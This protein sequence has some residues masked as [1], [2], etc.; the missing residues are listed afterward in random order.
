MSKASRSNSG[1]GAGALDLSQAVNYISQVAGALAYAHD[2]GVIHRDIKPANI[3]ITPYGLVKLMD[4]GIASASRDSR[5]TKTGTAVGSLFYMSPEQITGLTPDARSDLYSLGVTFYEMVTGRRPIEGANDYTI[6][7]GHMNQVPTAPMLV[8]PAV[9][10]ELSQVIVV[11]LSKNPAERFQ[12]ASHLRATLEAQQRQRDMQQMTVP[13]PVYNTPVP[14]SQSYT[15]VPPS[16]TPVPTSQKVWDPAVL[17]K[18]R[19]E[20]AQ[21][22]GPMAKVLVDRTSRK[23]DTLEQLYD[24]LAAEITSPKDREKFL[25]SRPR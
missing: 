17:D 24:K 6:M 14:P 7:T 5:L 1:S 25:S 18:V 16:A 19:R 4:F 13:M 9:P 8:N 20:Y 2:H 10:P 15:P 11:L 21:Y 12:A 23:V 3:M 22:I